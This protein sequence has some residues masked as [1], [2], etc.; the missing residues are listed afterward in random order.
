[1]T[2]LKSEQGREQV[3]EHYVKAGCSK[4][5]G[6]GAKE[7]PW[8]EVLMFFTPEQKGQWKKPWGT[9]GR[10]SEPNFTAPPMIVLM[11]TIQD[12]DFPGDVEELVY[13][14]LINLNVENLTELRRACSL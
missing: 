2:N 11:R 13:F 12:P 1:M 9:S 8:I 6:H 14:V 5:E 4:Q 7:K 10:S 3:F